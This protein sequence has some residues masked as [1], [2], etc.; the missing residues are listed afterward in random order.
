MIR[1]KHGILYVIL[2]IAAVYGMAQTV[3]DAPQPTINNPDIYYNMGVQAFTEGNPGQATLQY[4]RALRLNSAHKQART[5]LDLAIR[6]SPDSEMYPEHLFL[7]RVLIQFWNY[8]SLN[9]LALLCLVL[10]A[11]SA[12]AFLWL[13]FYD[14]QK[15]IALPLIV[16]GFVTLLCLLGFIMLAYKAHAQNHNQKA[17]LMVPSAQLMPQNDNSTKPLAEIH[18]GL[19]LRVLKEENGLYIV[20]LPNGLMGKLPAEAVQFVQPRD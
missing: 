18:A 8:L 10:L 12:L 7:V 2:L 19:I 16:T 17:V 4:L 5:N 9:R 6:M 3:T 20:I 1:I 14:P 13:M 15:E 11:L